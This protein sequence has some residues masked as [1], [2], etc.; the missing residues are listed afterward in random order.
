MDPAGVRARRGPRGPLSIQGPSDRPSLAKDPAPYGLFVP[1]A[2]FWRKGEGPREAKMTPAILL[3]LALCRPTP[4]AAPCPIDGSRAAPTALVPADAQ[5][6]ESG[7]V[8]GDV[9]IVVGDIFDEEHPR[10]RLPGRLV[11]RLHPRTRRRV[12]EG[13]LLFRAGDPYRRRLLEESERLLRTDRYLR[14][15]EVR[16][17]AYDGN[18]VV[19]EVAARDVWTLNAGVSFGHA[20]G[21]SSSRFELEDANFLGTGKHVLLERRQDVD[22]VTT[23][24]GLTDPALLGSRFRLDLG[25]SES[26][27]GGGWNVALERPF[28]SLDSR[29]SFALEGSSGERVDAR[30]RLGHVADRFQHEAARFELRGG[31]S[32]GLEAGRV[33]RWTAGLTYQRDR[34][35]APAG[36]TA[37]APPDR[38]LVYPWLGWDWQRDTFEEATN[39]DLIGRV[40]DVHLGPRLHARVG[41]ASPLVGADRSALL[42]DGSAGWVVAPVSRTLLRFATNASGRLEAGGLANALVHASGQAYW[43]D[44]GEHELYVGVEGDV[45]HALDPERQITLGGDTGL[46]GYPLR[47]QAGDSRLLVTVEQRI[48]TDWYP[49]RLARVG[50]AAFYDLGRV[51]GGPEDAARGWLH[52]LGIGLRLAPSRTGRAAV[53][54]LD[55]A[56]PLGGPREVEGVQWLVRSRSTF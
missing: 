36:S 31:A 45:A 26:S 54:H 5:L 13:Q 17:V 49:L 44:F 30:Y 23:R 35:G 15:V 29:W 25:L 48:F 12:I 24:L 34:F 46:R 33:T 47:Y 21:A 16:P 38:T 18:R 10:E 37:A 8:V 7:A 27:D 53:I 51:W 56:L 22:R 20:G 55:L 19:V 40:E 42:V 9:R 43:R 1:S 3:W 14:D 28:Y 6:E 4:A 11:N 39:L 32:G 52:D 41:V 2:P 50:A